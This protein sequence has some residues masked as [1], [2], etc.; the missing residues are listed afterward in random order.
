MSRATSLET[1]ISQQ[2]QPPVQ[3]KTAL[4]VEDDLPFARFIQVVLE[5]NGYRATI[6]LNAKEALYF[7]HHDTPDLITLDLMM[8][9]KTGIKLYRELRT[10]QQ[11][12]NTKIVI[13]T[14]VDSDSQGLCSYNEFFNRV[15]A[16]G[17]VEKPD[18]YLT[19]PIAGE[20]LI[21]EIQKVM[22]A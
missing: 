10:N 15:S 14:G 8:P 6:A 17:Q 16:R 22:D 7:I 9:D 11:L 3:T 5:D 21:R 18:A 4:I 19:K 12:K 20:D 1:P 13:L 2:K